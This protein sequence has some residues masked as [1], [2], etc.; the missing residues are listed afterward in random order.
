MGNL[1]KELE[2]VYKC[3]Y[4]FVNSKINDVECSKDITQAVMEI[5]LEKYDTLRKKESLK[6]WIMQI[7]NNKVKSYYGELR[8]IN[9]IFIYQ[10][11]DGEEQKAGDIYNVVDVKTDILGMII[12]KEDKISLI[13]ALK[14][15]DKNYQEVIRLNYI[16]GYNFIEISEILNV[17]V[18]T[19]RTWSARGLIK[20]KEEFMKAESRK[21]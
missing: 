19:V 4:C 12:S 21:G 2:E 1:E 15:L 6:A 7:A 10:G 18:N 13:N 9:S 17:N 5:A 16:C 11:R 20:L 8:R 14:N 3:V